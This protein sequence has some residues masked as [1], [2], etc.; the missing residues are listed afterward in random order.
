MVKY[1]LS[2]NGERIRQYNV[3]QCSFCKCVRTESCQSV[4]E[5]KR[6]NG[7]AVERPVFYNF[8]SSVVGCGCQ[9]RAIFKSRLLYRCNGCRYSYTTKRRT[10]IKRIRADVANGRCKRYSRNGRAVHKCSVADR[11]KSFS[12]SNSTD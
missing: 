4:F 12:E 10:A 11:N 6:R 8:N 5:I 3:C 1:M 7:S 9:R 2:D